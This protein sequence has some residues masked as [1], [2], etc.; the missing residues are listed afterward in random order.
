MVIEVKTNQEFK[1]VLESNEKVVAK[2]FAKWCGSCRLFAPKYKR[3][4]DDERFQE[5]AFVNIDTEEN[6]EAK[7]FLKELGVEKIET[8]PHITIFK[9]GVPV[10]AK[11]TSKEEVIVEMLG[12]IK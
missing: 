7:T 3:M 8:I 4:S 12:K 9:N 1:K 6:P 5:I 2:H 10:E 11:S